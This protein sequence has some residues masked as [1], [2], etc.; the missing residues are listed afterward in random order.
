MLFVLLILSLK[1]VPELKELNMTKEVP[2]EEA[3]DK[4][5]V[6]CTSTLVLF[7]A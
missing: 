5:S 4:L 1:Y 6:P 2:R 7:A 3:R